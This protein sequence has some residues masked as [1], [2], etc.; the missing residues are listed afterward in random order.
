MLPQTVAS[1]GA[2]RDSRFSHAAA[3][4]SGL[5]HDHRNR[6]R[7]IRAARF[8]A[9]AVR[10]V[11]VRDARRARD[12]V[13]DEQGAY[14]AAD[15]RRLAPTGSRRRSTASSRRS[16]RCRARRAGETRRRRADAAA[17]AADGR[18]GRSPRGAS[19]RR[20][21]TCRFRCRSSTRNLVENAGAFN[22]NRLKE[23]IPTV[24]FYSTNPRNSAINIRG[25][26]A[27]F[28]LT[29]DGLEPGV[30][31][32]ID[33]VFYARPASATLDFLDIERIEVLRGPQGTLFGK[34]T[35][36]G[37]INVTTRKPQLHARRRLRAQCRRSRLRAGQ[38]LGD[39]ARSAARSPGGVSFSGTQRDGTVY[40]TRTQEHVNDLDNAGVR[41]QVLDRAVRQ[42]R[43]PV[44]DRLQPAAARRLHAGRRRRRA[45]AAAGQ[46]PVSADCRRPRLHAA[47]LQ[48]LRSPHRRRHAAALVPGSRRLGGERRLEGWRAAC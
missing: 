30:G 7:R 20:R 25:L 42:G 46:S 41:G 16:V 43:D 38:G 8:P 28:G 48:R 11:N 44:V 31:L 3:G 24:Q 15:L 36:A 34:N 17:G 18:G 23:L 22:V 37:A 2:G 1:R 12:A 45:D 26:G 9:P 4:T 39:R 40:N 27:P 32:Y 33:G 6:A 10:I 47:E 13:S 29:N 14:R 35:T 5:G 21:R 19:R